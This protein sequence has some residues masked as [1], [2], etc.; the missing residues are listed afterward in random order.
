MGDYSPSRFFGVWSG[1]GLLIDVG[2]PLEVGA[3]API[4]FDASPTLELP[5]REYQI[6]EGPPVGATSFIVSGGRF[7]SP[8]IWWAQD[9]SWF[10]ATDI[11]ESV[12]YIGGSEDLVRRLLSDPR[13]EVTRSGPNLSLFRRF[14]PWLVERVEAACDEVLDKGSAEVVLSMGTVKFT[15]D[16]VG[17]RKASLSTRSDN[18]LGA[19]SSGGTGPVSTRDPEEFRANV[20]LHIEGAIISLVR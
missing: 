2:T 4:R 17:W 7:Q 5:W 15:L 3:P 20:R 6:Y 9:R 16:K 1:Y 11:D 10:V 14:S 13:L 8:N 18:V 12:T 19:W